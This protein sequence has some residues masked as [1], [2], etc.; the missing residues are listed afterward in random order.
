MRMKTTYESKYID[1][2]VNANKFRNFGLHPLILDRINDQIKALQ[3]YYS[4]ITIYRFDLHLPSTQKN[5]SKLE[6]ELLS[7]LFKRCKADLGSKKWRSHK[8]FIHGW[9]RETGISSHPHYHVF[10]GLQSLQRCAGLVSENGLTGV[11]QIIEKH[12]KELSGGTVHCVN[13][14]ILNRNDSDAYEK[15]FFHLSYLAKDRDKDFGSG[16]SHKRFGFSRLKCKEEFP[17]SYAA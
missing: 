12:W 14:R 5:P 8:R 7:L 1:L 11:W 4:R 16:E 6:N 2:P 15:C 10:I 3:S 9:V 17:T 13:A